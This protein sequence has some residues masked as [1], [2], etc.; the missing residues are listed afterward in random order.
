MG[1]ER[2]E[3]CGEDL[4]E[5]GGVVEVACGRAPV[6]GELGSKMSFSMATICFP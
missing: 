5:F 2:L 3:G 1:M 4:W 6:V